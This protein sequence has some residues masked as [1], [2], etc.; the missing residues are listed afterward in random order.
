MLPRI[1]PI[2]YYLKI[3]DGFCKNEIETTIRVFLCLKKVCLFG[4]IIAYIYIVQ[5]EE[6]LILTL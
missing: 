6:Y 2:S 5:R 1:L 4:G 3:T